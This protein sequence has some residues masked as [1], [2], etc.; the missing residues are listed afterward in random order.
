MDTVGSCRTIYSGNMPTGTIAMVFHS[1]HVLSC[2]P[3]CGWNELINSMKTEG[4][5]D[6]RASFK[7]ERN[8]E[9]QKRSPGAWNGTKVDANLRQGIK[10]HKKSMVS[11]HFNQGLKMQASIA[12][13]TTH[14]VRFLK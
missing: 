5:N 1:E 3:V 4:Q 6:V 11:Q 2:S 14:S 12:K 13:K 9:K 8:Q 7:M 10:N